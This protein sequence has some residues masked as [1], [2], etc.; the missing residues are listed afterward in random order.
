MPLRPVARGFMTNQ[1]ILGIAV[2]V[3][4]LLIAYEAVETW[5]WEGFANRPPSRFRLIRALRG[6]LAGLV[7]IVTLRR[8]RKPPDEPWAP[9]TDDDLAYRLGP[10]GPVHL[11]PGRIV[12][13]GARVPPPQPLQAVVPL[14]PP[15]APRPSRLRLARDMIGAALV[16]G[17]FVVVFA[18]LMPPSGPVPTPTGGVDAAF[19]TPL[20]SFEIRTAAPAT[21]EPSPLSEASIAPA[22]S[23]SETVLVSSTAHADDRADPGSQAG[24]TDGP[25]ADRHAASDPAPRSPRQSPP[26]SRSRRPRPSRPRGSRRSTRLRPQ[27]QP[28]KPSHS[29]TSSV[30]ARVAQ[31]RSTTDRARRTVRPRVVRAA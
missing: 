5:R 7:S 1:L 17:G 30:M 2:V 10:P 13:S 14:P 3:V 21:A 29:A 20:P 8:W 25:A 6:G 19:A 12:V 11:A 4:A 31:S 18:N 24:P 22:P 27:P 9:M 28:A 16:M 26:R 23:P 15:V